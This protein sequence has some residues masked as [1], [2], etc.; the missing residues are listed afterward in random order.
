MSLKGKVEGKPELSAR[1]HEEGSRGLKVFGYEPERSLR[2]SDGYQCSEKHDPSCPKFSTPS[3]RHQ[4]ARPI[5]V[6]RKNTKVLE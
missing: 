2:V 5:A 6:A 4:I 1:L 3:A